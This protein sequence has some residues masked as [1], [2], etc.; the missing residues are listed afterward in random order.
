MD[1]IIRNARKLQR[2]TDDV[3]DITRIETKSLRLKKDTFD[4]KELIQVLVD[5]YK[6]QNNDEK[7][8]DGKNYSNIE[9]SLLPSITEEPPKCRSFS[10]RSR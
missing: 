7:K 5:D 9:L 3:L 1:V 6:I 10:Y 8:N 2:L 4:L